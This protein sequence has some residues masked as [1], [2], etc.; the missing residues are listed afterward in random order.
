MEITQ[1][2]IENSWEVFEIGW[3]SIICSSTIYLFSIDLLAAEIRCNWT[4]PFQF[5]GWGIWESLRLRLTT[6]LFKPSCHAHWSFK[7][8]GEIKK[9]WSQISP[10]KPLKTFKRNQKSL[11]Y[12]SVFC[13]LFVVLWNISGIALLNCIPS[14]PVGIKKHRKKLLFKI[15]HWWKATRMWFAYPIV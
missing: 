7:T 8:L 3:R 2:K 5:L 6:F 13:Y 12:F 11:K 9:N 1:I 4:I 15:F 10:A 14:Q